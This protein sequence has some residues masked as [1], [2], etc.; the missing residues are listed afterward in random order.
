RYIM[1][2]LERILPGLGFN[3]PMMRMWY[4]IVALASKQGKALNCSQIGVVLRVTNHTVRHYVN[5]LLITSLIRILEPC[6]NN[7]S[8][9]KVKSP[10]VFIRDSGLLHT[11]V[12]V[13]NNDQL[14]VYPRL[15]ASWEGFALEEIIKINNAQ[16]EECFFWGVQGGAELD[17]LIIKNGKRI[18][19]EIKYTD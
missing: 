6:F 4:L 18:G 10:K 1:H 2:V 3:I 14:Q 8:K 13:Q 19:F 11:L 17:L 7:I 9:R 12:G 16:R 15:S 5:I